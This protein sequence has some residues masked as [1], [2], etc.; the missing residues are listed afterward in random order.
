MKILLILGRYLP[1]KNGGI[2]NYCHLLSNLLLSSHHTIE[3]AILES[4]ETEPYI[5]DKVRVYPFNG[6]FEKYKNLLQEN[7]YD[8]CHFQE[9]SAFGG[10]E[11]FWLKEARKY[12]KKIFFTFHLPY[13][14]CYK[15]D[16]RYFGIQDCNDFS[17]LER[18]V[19]C[20]IA[21]RLHYKKHAAVNIT[22]KVIE[23]VL[24]YLEKTNKANNLKSNIQVN[25]G[26]LDELIETCDKIF[27]IANWFKKMLAA[28]GH[29]SL[30]IS[31]I[32]PLVK[33]AVDTAQ[34]FP[35][36]VKHKLLFVGRIEEQKGLHL[37]CHAMNVIKTKNIRLDVFGYKEDDNYFHECEKEYAFT[38]EGT[39]PREALL[40][41]L[42][43]YDF[44]VLPS[45]CTEMYS[46]ILQEALTAGIPIIASSAKGNVD[47][48]HDGING[49]L[50][51]YD[52]HYDLASVIDKAYQM[53]KN[54]WVPQFH[55]SNN[56]ENDLKEILSYY[57]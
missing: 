44:L 18:C 53:L 20:V 36:S 13:F 39:L 19:K 11:M 7:Q 45:V 24:P 50:F 9:Y 56:Y 46:L 54:K 29:T 47:L 10:I 23:L 32:P 5:F 12:C 1:N 30:R 42:T 34:I 6:N 3:I 27:V 55:H 22:N 21:T 38:F 17:S 15:N 2:E 41:R 51:N 26:H 49:F 57:N 40:S 48:I 35:N 33:P 25:T 52:D 43:E 31:L 37:L 4:P 16:F 8:I 14:T 28:N